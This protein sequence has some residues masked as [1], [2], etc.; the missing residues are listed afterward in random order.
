LPGMRQSYQAF[1]PEVLIRLNQL[2]KEVNHGSL[3]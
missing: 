1:G 2:I 3:P